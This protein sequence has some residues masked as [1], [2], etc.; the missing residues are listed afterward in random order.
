M[1]ASQFN[2]TSRETSPW[3]SGALPA[4]TRASV[5]GL[6]PHWSATSCHN[7]ARA[8]R[9][10]SRRRYSSQTSRRWPLTG[11]WVRHQRGP[12]RQVRRGSGLLPMRRWGRARVGRIRCTCRTSPRWGRRICGVPARCG[13][14]GFGRS[15]LLTAFSSQPPHA[16]QSTA[17]DVR[18][19]VVCSS[20]MMVLIS[21]RASVR[22]HWVTVHVPAAVRRP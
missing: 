9:W 5:L 12:R 20:V 21:R 14:G 8:R 4:L 1:A 19:P 7:R 10:A 2:Q 3:A 18:L 11:Y 13:Q 6:R 22:V 15:F 17:M 16:G